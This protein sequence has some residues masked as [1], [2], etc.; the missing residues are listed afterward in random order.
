MRRILRISSLVLIIVVMMTS[1]ALAG[2]DVS[3]EVEPGTGGPAEAQ[4]GPGPGFDSNPLPLTGVDTLRLFAASLTLIAIGSVFLR[5][6]RRAD[7]RNGT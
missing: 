1:V 2:V 3:L 5:N 6:R 4:G 7:E